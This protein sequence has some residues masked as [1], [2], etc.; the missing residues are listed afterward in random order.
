MLL[1]QSQNRWPRHHD[2]KNPE[3]PV[4]FGI[5]LVRSIAVLS[6]LGA[7]LLTVFL[8]WVLYESRANDPA[9]YGPQ[10]YA[11]PVSTAR[12]WDGRH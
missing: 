12:G 3:D 11:G 7:A 6:G 1:M 8:A 10:H 9:D 5:V 4:M 2:A